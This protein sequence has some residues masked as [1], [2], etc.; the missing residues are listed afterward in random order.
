MRSAEPIPAA[1]ERSAEL[2]ESYLGGLAA[3]GVS[4]SAERL[5][6]HVLER[7]LV[8][9]GEADI[10]AV[11]EEHLARF[12][13]TLKGLSP[14]TRRAYLGVVRR[15]FAAL[16]RRGRLLRSPAEELRTPSVDALP[17]RVPSAAQMVRLLERAGSWPP[18]AER[19]RAILEVLYGSGLRR[20]E[21]AQLDLGDVDL[22]EGTLWVRCGK[23]RKG[24]VV[25]LTG[26]AVTA[27]MRYLRDSRPSLAVDPCEAALFLSERGG[28]RLTDT[29]IARVV[30][31]EAETVQ[32]RLSPH[33]LRHACATHLLQGGASI[34]LIQR[35][36]GHR[37]LA[38]TSRYT[39]VDT[40]ALASML[41]RCHPRER[42][43][44]TTRLRDQ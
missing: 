3:K 43:E 36:L 32:L 15:F 18:T 38:T 1:A 42:R 35:L 17:R 10:R 21:C 33:S 9:F 22:G 14:G 12:A 20:S 44:S 8:F 25:P 39:R 16:V 24:R 4:R 11:R 34:R 41:R 2:V 7:L 27:L 40:A 37:S 30:H 6:R 5:A 23:G 19:D 26:R 28:G 13:G 29:A 31:R